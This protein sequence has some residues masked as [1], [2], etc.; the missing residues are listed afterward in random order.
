MIYTLHR[1]QARFRGL[2]VRQKFK[3]SKYHN[4]QDLFEKDDYTHYREAA[5][6]LITENHLR[7][8]FQKYKALNDNIIVTK[9]QPVEF[10]NKAIYYGE[11]NVATNQRHGRGIQVWI[12]GSRYEGYWKNDKANIKGR[13]YHA[14]GDI[15]EGSWL[16]DK[17]HGYGTYIHTDGAKYEGQWKDDKQD[18]V[19]RETWP[20]LACYMGDYKNGKKSGKG[21][22]KW[23]DKSEYDGDFLDNN[24]HG[25]G[26][27]FIFIIFNR[28]LYLE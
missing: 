25:K 3:S 24:I 4:N 8:L 10:D 13:L 6:S 7:D 19:G 1:I 26:K 11:W 12:D 20:D 27:K 5:S 22:F 28:S 16:D 21:K 23:A 2:L 15:Y 9:R 17:A 14:D 18:G